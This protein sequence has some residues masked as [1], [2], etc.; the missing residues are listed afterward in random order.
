[1]WPRALKV[2]GSHLA[3]LGRQFLERE[4]ARNLRVEVYFLPWEEL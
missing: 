1:V 4:E 3:S 2:Y